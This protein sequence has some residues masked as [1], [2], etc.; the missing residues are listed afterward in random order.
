[1]EKPTKA[2]IADPI[3]PKQGNKPKNN[4]KKYK[5]K[6]PAPPTSSPLPPQNVSLPQPARSSSSAILPSPINP[7][8]SPILTPTLSTNPPPSHPQINVPQQLK[9]VSNRQIHQL[10]SNNLSKKVYQP[11]KQ[12]GGTG[13]EHIVKNALSAKPMPLI[14]SEN[15]KADNEKDNKASLPEPPTYESK[16]NKG[17]AHKQPQPQQEKIMSSKKVDELVIKWIKDEKDASKR[18]LT[19]DDLE[20][21]IGE[22]PDV[23]HD[24]VP[25][26]FNGLHSLLLFLSIFLSILYYFNLFHPIVCF[27]F[28][29]GL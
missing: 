6:P 18:K 23:M 20:E 11:I 10:P 26:V 14:L 28:K 16:K 5:P 4:N 19:T 29:N 27:Y 1:M 15:K 2:A 17:K 22:A 25:E 12:K 13:I 21:L 24:V 8:P 9:P 7:I 3:P